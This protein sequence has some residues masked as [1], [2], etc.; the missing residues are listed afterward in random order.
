MIYQTSVPN[1][2]GI[3]NAFTR[4][5]LEGKYVSAQDALASNYYC[6]IELDEN[7]KED[8]IYEDVNYGKLT[9]IKYDEMIAII[10]HKM[11]LEIL[12]CDYCVYRMRVNEND[13]IITKPEMISIYENRILDI[14]NAG[15][16]FILNK[17]IKIQGLIPVVTIE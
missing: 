8:F 15:Y 17:E 14:K 13:E 12:K 1:Y 16:D 3:F 6:N 4:M 9:K 7:D 5:N 11:Y 10:N 2:D